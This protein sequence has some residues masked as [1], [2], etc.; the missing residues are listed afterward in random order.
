MTDGTSNT[1]IIAEISGR[2][3]V[4]RSG[5]QVASPTPVAQNYWSGGGGWNDASSGDFQLNGEPASGA[6]AYSA[7]STGG[8]IS[9]PPSS[10]PAAGS[11]LINCSNEYGFYAFHPG[12]ANSVF[13]DGSVHFLSA[14]ISPALLVGLVTKA[15]GEIL[16]GDY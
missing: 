1:L 15:N 3:V 13:A 8:P 2:P 12:G 16:T 6:T 10:R 14:N 11:C 7:A 4:W 5:K 9:P